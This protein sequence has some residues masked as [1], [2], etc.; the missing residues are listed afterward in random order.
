MANPGLTPTPARSSSARPRGAASRAA[1]PNVESPLIRGAL[2]ILRLFLGATFLYAG[3][4]KL[5]DPAFLNATGPGSIG[6]QLHV[7]IF[8]SPLAPLVRSFALPAPIAIGVL[9]ALGE[10]AVG[11]GTLT[12]LLFRAAAAGGLALS[13]LFWLTAS[14]GTH[15]FYYGADLPF[16]VGWLVLLISGNTGWSLIPYLAR[17]VPARTSQPAIGEVLS[18]RDALLLGLQGATIA[19][20]SLI[21]GA[22]AWYGTGGPTRSPQD[23]RAAVPTPPPHPSG[24]PRIATPPPGTGPLVPTAPPGQVAFVSD[25]QPRHALAITDP[26]SGDPAFV[27]QTST[28]SII[29]YDALCTH[30]RCTVD[31]DGSSGLFICPCHGA[32]FDPEHDGQVLLEPAKDPLPQLPLTIDPATGA[33]TLTA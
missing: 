8:T 11:I 18:R 12:G 21:V 6:S 28:G 22:F 15:P 25:L 14:W 16:A 2:L 33:I 5:T 20:T 3:L 31:F 27:Y 24:P 17:F 30:E 10:I 1:A 9:I 26:L 19:V 32:V 13:I 23:L 4:D 7:F 29:A